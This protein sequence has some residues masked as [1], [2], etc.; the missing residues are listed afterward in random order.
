MIATQTVRFEE[1]AM[2]LQDSLIR[3]ARGMTQNAADAEDLVQETFL[4]G[5][6]FFDRF[7]QGRHFKPWIFT[8]LRN[9]FI[10]GTRARKR[11]P[12][13]V[14]MDALD[15]PLEE[16]TLSPGTDDAF[17]V[18]LDQLSENGRRAVLLADVGGYSYRE[19]ADL[20]DWPMST[21]MSRLFEARKQLRAALE[22]VAA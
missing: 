9:T 19:M 3:V 22:T 18:A 7:E 21:V 2:P 5:F 1:L 12:S 10:S 8:I 6:R 13:T 17:E 20:M 14:S 15:F 11:R 16:P 4:R